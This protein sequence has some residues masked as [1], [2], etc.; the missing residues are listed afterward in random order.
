MKTLYAII[1]IV[2][3]LTATLSGIRVFL[4]SEYWCVIPMIAG[5]VAGVYARVMEEKLKKW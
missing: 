2:G 1:Y 5:V 3:L 4:H